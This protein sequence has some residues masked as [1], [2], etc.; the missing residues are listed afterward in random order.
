MSAR[1]PPN[2]RCWVG[3]GIKNAGMQSYR[4]RFELAP[5]TVSG[6]TTGNGQREFQ[7]VGAETT[8]LRE[9][10][11]VRTWG[12]NNNLSDERKVRDGV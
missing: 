6:D 1:D 2:L 9:P 10:K 8:T 7:I 4:R 5:K 11:H 3:W 12:T